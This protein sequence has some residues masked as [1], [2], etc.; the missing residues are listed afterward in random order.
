MKPQEN[1]KETVV[2]KLQRP[3]PSIE[4]RQVRTMEY[5]INEIKVQVSRV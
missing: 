5:Y 4:K 2:S 3:I 1:V